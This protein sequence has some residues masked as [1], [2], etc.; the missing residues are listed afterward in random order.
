MKTYK[1]FIIILLKIKQSLLSKPPPPSF[2]FDCSALTAQPRPLARFQQPCATSLNFDRKM[3]EK[4]KL[5][6]CSS[7]MAGHIMQ[8]KD[9]PLAMHHLCN[10]YYLFLFLYSP[11]SARCLILLLIAGYSKRHL[12]KSCGAIL[13]LFSEKK[14]VIY[15]SVE[16]VQQFLIQFQIAWKS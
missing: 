11:M 2:M 15:F 16:T 9:E 3:N 8:A 6:N 7:V 13:D 1:S 12:L 10:C 5:Q 4:K 14:N